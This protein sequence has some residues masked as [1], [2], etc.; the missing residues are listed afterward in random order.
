IRKRRRERLCSGRLG[1]ACVMLTA[2]HCVEDGPVAINA[3]F[4]PTPTTR[5]SY[6]VVGYV[7]HPEYHFPVA[8][9]AMLLLAAPVAGVNPV[10]LVGRTPRPRTLGTIVGYGQHELG[11]VALQQG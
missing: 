2:G 6:A 4:F 5:A 1:S 7:M 10:P 9:L 8:D 3:T 11:K